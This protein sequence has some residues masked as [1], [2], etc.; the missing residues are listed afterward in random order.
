MFS[1]S[2]SQ[3]G[4][5]GKDEWLEM[6]KENKTAICTTNKCYNS[7]RS[8]K[9]GAPPLAAR[10]MPPE[11][12]PLR[13]NGPCVRLNQ[14]SKQYCKNEEHIVAFRWPSKFYPNCG[15]PLG[16]VG[17]FLGDV[18]SLECSPGSYLNVVG[19]CEPEWEFD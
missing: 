4:Y 15:P 10:D 17:R 6:A 18:S 12:V 5:C 7:G 9:F 1:V 16:V 2:Y 14:S 3:Q 13:G 8:S 11:Y 19:T